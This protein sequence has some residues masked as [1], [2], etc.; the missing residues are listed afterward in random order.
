MNAYLPKLHG[1]VDGERVASCLR[2][3]C[4]HVSTCADNYCGYTSVRTLTW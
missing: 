4:V 2:S 3:K 1:A